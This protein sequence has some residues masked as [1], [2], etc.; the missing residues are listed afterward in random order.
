M[1]EIPPDILQALQSWKIAFD[2]LRSG[3]A[4]LKDTKDLLSAPQ[5]DEVETRIAE[6]DLEVKVAEAALAKSLGYPLHRCQFPPTIMINVGYT[7]NGDA[8]HECPVCGVTDHP[9]FSFTRTAPSRD[10]PTA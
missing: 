1:Q 4:L 6:L 8:V 9:G 5:R 10:R 7:R 3:L 2:T